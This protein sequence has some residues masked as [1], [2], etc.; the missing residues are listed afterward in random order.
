[1]GAAE[2][3][4]CMPKLAT[5]VHT[6]PPPRPSTQT[7]PC[8]LEFIARQLTACQMADRTACRG[9]RQPH[10]WT[11]EAIAAGSD[12]NTL[13]AIRVGCGVTLSLFSVW[14]SPGGLNLNA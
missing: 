14:R 5:C 1:M 2:V 6:H 13:D 12:C 4:F 10:I 3:H 8:Q 7:P 9:W 11:Y